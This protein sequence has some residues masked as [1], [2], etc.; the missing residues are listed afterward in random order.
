MSNPWCY[1]RCRYGGDTGAPT[2]GEISAAVKELYEESLPGMTE[3]DYEEHGSASLR[4]GYDE[5]PMYVLEITR[6]G[7]ARW[8]VR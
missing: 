8:E 3:G 4:Y 5:G 7:N 2:R 1:L 6:H